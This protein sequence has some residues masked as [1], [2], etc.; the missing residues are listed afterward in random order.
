MAR[1]EEKVA[2]VTGSASGIGR[3]TA[4][5]LAEEGARVFCADLNVAGVEES[6]QTIRKAGGE[7]IARGCDVSDPEAC[8]ATVAAALEAFGRLDSLCNIAGVGVHAHATDVTVEQW[9]RSIG[10]NLSGAFFMCQAAIPHLLETRGSIVNMASSAGLMGIA[11]SAPYCASKGGLVMLTR[12][13][14]V[15]YGKRGLRVNCVCPG[16]VMTPMTMSFRPPE[17]ADPDLLRR[18]RLVPQLAEPAEIAAAVAYL[19]SDEARYVNG[20][21]LAIDGGLAA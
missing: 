6:A 11:Y 15:E 18:M 7:A 8:R 9:N 3:A 1:L 13:L 12:S 20:A 2:L 19:A 4:E 5:R 17:G 14:A 21:T 16:G 10:I